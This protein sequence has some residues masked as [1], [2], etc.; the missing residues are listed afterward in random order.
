MTCL[1]ALDEAI[2]ALLKNKDSNKYRDWLNARV[3]GSTAPIEKPCFIY[4][5]KTGKVLSKFH[6]LLRSIKKEHYHDIS[7][8]ANKLLSDG[9]RVEEIIKALLCYAK[10]VY[11]KRVYA[12]RVYATTYDDLTACMKR[13]AG[14][15]ML[16]ALA[17]AN[18]TTLKDINTYIKSQLTAEELKHFIGDTLTVEVFEKAR[19]ELKKEAAAKPRPFSKPLKIKGASKPLL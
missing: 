11:A 1:C 16:K 18:T 14:D 15:S 13:L 10:R 8:Y 2:T 17:L 9:V 6:A 12:K 5:P 19:G 3:N 4:I 7:Y